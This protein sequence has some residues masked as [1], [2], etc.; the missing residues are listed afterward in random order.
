MRSA[1][2]KRRLDVPNWEHTPCQ[3]QHLAQGPDLPVG[4][5]YTLSRRHCL[6]NAF[7][8]SQ[9]TPSSL[10]LPLPLMN[11]NMPIWGSLFWPPHCTLY[12]NTPGN[13]STGARSI[14][15]LRRYSFL[16]QHPSS[17]LPWWLRLWRI[18]LQ[19]GRPS[20]NPWVGKIPWRREQTAHS[21]LQI[22]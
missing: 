9:S 18:C 12:L 5:N 21:G 6:L 4:A 8:S 14:C 1:G 17:G 2:G 19:W 3:C 11:A 16:P 22:K 15:N 7:Y 13:N 10:F 20:F